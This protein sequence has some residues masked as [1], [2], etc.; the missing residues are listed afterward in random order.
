MLKRH[1]STRVRKY[2]KIKAGASIY[3]EEIMYFTMRMSYHNARMKRLLNL[4]RSQEFR[5]K[6]CKLR[7]MPED[8]IELHHVLDCQKERTGQIEF[9]HVH[10]HDSEH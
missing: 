3:S 2:I 7:F 6:K 9:M 8:V 4:L 1:D 10:C 5:C